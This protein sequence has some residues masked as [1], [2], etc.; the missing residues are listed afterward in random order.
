MA[1]YQKMY[2]TL[3]IAADSVIDELERIPLAYHACRVLKDALLEAEEIYIRSEEPTQ[4][5]TWQPSS[6]SG[7]L[8]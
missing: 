4:D 2:T 7:T 5:D 3:C 1:D 6:I 8:K